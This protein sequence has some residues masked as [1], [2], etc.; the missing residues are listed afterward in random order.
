MTDLD[1]LISTAD[2]VVCCGSGGVGKTTAAAALGLQAAGNGRHCVVVTIDPA[3]RLADA[4]GVPGG[5]TN[6][7]V[8]LPIEGSGEL[9]ALMLDTATTFDGLVVA[10]AKDSDQATRIL[11]NGFYRN[12]ASSLGGTQEYMAAERLLALH[13]D[14]RFDLVIVDTPPTR[15]ALDFLDA[16]RTLTRFID[17]PVF[18]MMM[19]PTRRG[20]RVLSI[21]AQ[22][23][24]R[25]IGKVIGSEVLADAVAFF[26]AFDGMQT[27][28]RNRA[29]EVIELLHGE[30]T[31]FVLVASPR[32]D[33]IDEARFFAGRLVEKNLGV[34][35]IIVNRATPDFG[36]PE[37]QRPS[38]AAKVA[39]Y[40]N[41][42][43]LHDLAVAEREHVDPLVKDTDRQPT[44]VP[45]LAGDVHDLDG[46]DLIR[47]L[48]FR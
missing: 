34:S 24:L 38:S 23:L 16:P 15:N 1:A 18:K 27:G 14:N 44:W 43:E 32:V 19:L 37:G 35:A 30:R 22:P 20:L 48:L 10:N 45:L 4:L 41:Q 8:R 21:A 31:R 7:P 25:S 40:D 28:F 46:L 2:V 5:L 3:K 42:A 12:I 11:T 17:H 29:D 33:T 36:A 39:L 47:S 9:W 6:D 26:Q 13:L